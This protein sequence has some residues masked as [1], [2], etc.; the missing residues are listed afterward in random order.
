[1]LYVLSCLNIFYNIYVK[2]NTHTHIHKIRRA[3]LNF[4]QHKKFL[5]QIFF[6]KENFLVR[7]VILFI[8]DVSNVCCR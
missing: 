6:Y 7:R 2:E 3:L 1:M 4:C 8:S 5:L